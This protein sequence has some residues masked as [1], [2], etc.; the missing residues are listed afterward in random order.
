MIAALCVSKKGCCSKASAVGRLALVRCKQQPKKSLRTKGDRRR[1]LLLLVFCDAFHAAT[2][3][4]CC[5]LLLMVLW[6]KEETQQERGRQRRRVFIGWGCCWPYLKWG[7]MRFNLSLMAAL[8]C[9]SAA[10]FSVQSID[11]MLR[12][13]SSSWTMH[14]SNNQQQQKQQQQQQQMNDAK[15]A[16]TQQQELPR[17]LSKLNVSTSSSSSSS[18]R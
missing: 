3:D 12:I 18:S 14:C 4:C 9:A 6:C 17:P 2:N 13:T 7:D 1:H 11:V 8:L 15:T 5:Q 16:Y 10:T